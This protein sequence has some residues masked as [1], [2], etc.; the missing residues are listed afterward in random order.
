M[1]I[2]IL[3]T[4]AMI[5]LSLC[6]VEAAPSHCVPVS[7]R[8]VNSATVESQLQAGARRSELLLAYTL[9]TGGAQRGSLHMQPDAVL[10]PEQQRKLRS[11][12]GNIDHTSRVIA[13]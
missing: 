5:T 1:W 12:P 4:A 3:I 2:E 6:A 9:G 13:M 11:E 7:A 10:S 8:D